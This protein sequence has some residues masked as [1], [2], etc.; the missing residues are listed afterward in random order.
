MIGYDVG[1]HGSVPPEEFGP[2]LRC[3][4]T[5]S[6]EYFALWRASGGKRLVDR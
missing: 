5:G 1:V 2:V 6:E 4:D 3:Q